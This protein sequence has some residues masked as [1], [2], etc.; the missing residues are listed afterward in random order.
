[1]A[2]TLSE[3]NEAIFNKIVPIFIDLQKIF[4]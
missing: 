1:M 4:F 3:E 2:K